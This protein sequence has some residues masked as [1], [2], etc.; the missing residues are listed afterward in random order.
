MS[1]WRPGNP[2]PDITVLRCVMSPS[3]YCHVSGASNL[4]SSGTFVTAEVAKGDRRQPWKVSIES[5]E[6]ATHF[7]K[8]EI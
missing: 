6:S 8:L 1:V 7:I 4:D 2:K 5:D 3:L